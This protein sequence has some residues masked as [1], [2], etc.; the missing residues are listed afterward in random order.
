MQVWWGA[1]QLFSESEKIGKQ[2][3]CVKRLRLMSA[4][5]GLVKYT[6]NRMCYIF[7]HSTCSKIGC[8]PCFLEGGMM[9]V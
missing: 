5:Q 1:K 4:I 9:T 8:M 7:S 6:Y 3:H 2:Q